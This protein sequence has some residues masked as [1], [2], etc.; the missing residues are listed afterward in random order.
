M[1]WK[2]KISS[3]LLFS[4]KNVSSSLAVQGTG[5]QQRTSS[6]ESIRDVQTPRSC[7]L[8][9]LRTVSLTLR[10]QCRRELQLS[11]TCVLSSWLAKGRY[12]DPVSNTSTQ[13]TNIPKTNTTERREKG[14]K[15][16]RSH[17][18][19]LKSPSLVLEEAFW[20]GIKTNNDCTHEYI[21]KSLV[22][23]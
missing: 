5:E 4:F 19:A 1:N 2:N 6:G 15:W 11:L 18:D 3:E 22:S 9:R 21:K 16:E 8:W 17:P 14:G 7:L 13:Q 20:S 12:Y 10:S 23:W